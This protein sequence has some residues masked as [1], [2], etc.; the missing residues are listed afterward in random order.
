M[1]LN[2]LKDLYIEQIKD[3]Y[4]AEEQLIKALPMMIEEACSVELRQA[5]TDHLEET[6]MQASRLEQIAKGLGEK[7]SG[8]TCQAMKG[9]I[10]EAN[11]ILKNKSRKTDEDVRDAAMIA[12]A[13]RVEHYEISGYGTARTYA[14]RLGRDQDVK[15]L[16]MTLN[17]EKN[18]DALLNRIAESVVNPRAASA[19]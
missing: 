19:R 7:P 4:S 5:L 9:L 2:T 3:L 15:L 16:E 14:A 6:R 18:A 11:E 13:Q 12:A 1:E 8:A 10:K 17:E